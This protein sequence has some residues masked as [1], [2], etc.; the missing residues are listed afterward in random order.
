LKKQPVSE[1]FGDKF[2]N[3]CHFEIKKAFDLKICMMIDPKKSNI[4]PE[5]YKILSIRWKVINSFVICTHR[6]TDAKR[7]ETDLW[8][9]DDFG[10]S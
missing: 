3:G 9:Y 1:I 4:Q 6:Q 2:L 10:F 5:F 8:S 7:N